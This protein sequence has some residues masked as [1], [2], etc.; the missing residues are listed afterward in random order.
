MPREDDGTPA[1]RDLRLRIALLEAAL[2]DKEDIE[3][4]LR[5]SE[6]RFRSIVETTLVGV[7]VL[8]CEGRTTFVNQRA[9]EMLGYEPAEML[10]QPAMQFILGEDL[11]AHRAAMARRHAGRRETYERRFCCKDGRVIWTIMN[12]TPLVSQTGEFTGSFATLTDITERKEAEG[13]LHALAELLDTVP[14]SITVHDR[15]GRFLYANRRTFEMHGYSESEF[16]ALNLRDVDIPESAALIDERM[17]L[18]SEAGEARF[19]VAH[20]C[21]DGT[22]VPLEVIARETTWGGKPVLLSVGTDITERKQAEAALSLQLDELRRWHAAT[23]GREKRIAELKREVNQLAE[24]LGLARPYAP[25]D[26]EASPEA[27]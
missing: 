21:S 4:R 1:L 23:L 26:E 18:I 17:R 9:A 27:A 19:E 12:G 15:Q 2:R 3:E 6:E 7:W 14:N 24:R 22:T 25:D 20:F 8:D 13:R 10:G 5:A 11:P 16:M